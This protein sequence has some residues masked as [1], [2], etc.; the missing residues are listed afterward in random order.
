MHLVKTLPAG[1]ID[2]IGDIHGEIEALSALLGKLG[3]SSLGH[4]PEGRRLVFVGDLV[5]RG[6][7]SPGVVRTVMSLVQA[8]VAEAILGNHELNLLSDDIKDGSGWFFDERYER[9]LPNYAPFT[10]TPS[11]EKVALRDFLQALPIALVREDIR[12]VHA[13]WTS[14]A[15]EAI[16][17]LPLGSVTD[18]YLKWNR[19]AQ[20]EA[21]SLGLY[22]QY[23]GEKHTWS[24][25]LESESHP[26]PEF[27]S[28]HAEYEALQQQHNP[29]K[30]LT[31]G[32]EQKTTAPFFAGHRWR[33]SDRTAWWQQYDDP[34]PVVIGHYWRQLYPQAVHKTPRYSLLF[35]DTSPLSW[36]GPAGNVFCIDYSVGARWRDRKA[37]R[38]INQS[39]FKLGALRWPENELVFDD[40]QRLPTAGF[41]NNYI[42]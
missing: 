9:D 28:A 6:P 16:S 34:V 8:G 41:T 3:Y 42:K 39:R 38:P 22:E 40:G 4:H 33:Y 20:Q 26:P 23:L 27:L 30:V 18:A 12:I 36:L 37:G 14:E 10:T 31:S 29:I 11:H 17:P 24:H 2:I 32:V 5:D 7:D 35:K 13:A 15:I 25:H 19:A 1:P 21:E